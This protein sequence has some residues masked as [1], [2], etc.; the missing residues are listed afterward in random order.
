MRKIVLTMAIAALGVL[1][2]TTA[3]ASAAP[4]ATCNYAGNVKLSPGLSNT[5]KTQNITIKGTLSGCTGEEPAVTSG[6]YVAH[7]KT[8]EPVTCTALTTAPAATE[9]TIVLKWGIGNSHGTFSEPLNEE[10][11][12]GLSGSVESG[13][14]AGLAISGSAQET[15]IE[16]ANCGGTIPGKKHPKPAKAV[17]KG[18]TSG[19]LTIS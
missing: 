16:G 6:T 9:G 11:P 12:Q 18:T 2:A 10:L 15:F 7:L 5:A 4:N 1:G 14:F 8:T 19:T 17:K 13:P 3:S